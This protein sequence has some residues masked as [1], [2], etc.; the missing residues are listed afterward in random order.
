MPPRSTLSEG[1]C[2]ATI[3]SFARHFALATVVLMTA[4]TPAASM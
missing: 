3:T 1:F 2:T 4:G